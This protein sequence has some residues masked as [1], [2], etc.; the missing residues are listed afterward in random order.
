ME[1]PRDI[2]NF[3]VKKLDIETR[4]KLGIISKFRKDEK[5]LELANS[6]THVIPNIPKLDAYYANEEDV[7]IELGKSRYVIARVFNRETKTHSYNYVLH[8]DNNR[9]CMFIDC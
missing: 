5:F 2:H 8:F 4:M 1:F 9:N 7:Y 6:L 3:I